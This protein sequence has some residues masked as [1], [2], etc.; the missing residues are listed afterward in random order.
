LSQPVAKRISNPIPATNI[1][2]FMLLALG[3]LLLAI[4]KQPTANGY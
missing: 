2:L 3:Y 4:G 1:V